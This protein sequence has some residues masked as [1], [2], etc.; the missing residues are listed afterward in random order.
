MTFS[1]E[2]LFDE[3]VVTIMDDTAELED[4]KLYFTD[5][6]LDIVQ[7]T[8]MEDVEIFNGVSLSHEMLQDLLAA[9]HRPEGLYR[10]S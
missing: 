6:G 5:S 4:V 2:H 1:V 9:Y 10:R 7:I 3:T 8:F